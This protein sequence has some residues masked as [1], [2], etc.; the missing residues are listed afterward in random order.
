MRRSEKGNFG[1]ACHAFK[2]K[3]GVWPSGRIDWA[4]R[5]PVGDEVRRY[6]TYKNIRYAKRQAAQRNTPE[7]LSQMA[8]MTI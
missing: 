3:F 4:A 7:T 6:I 8:E 2:E 5:L 1:W